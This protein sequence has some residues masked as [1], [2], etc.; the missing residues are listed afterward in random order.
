MSWPEP[1][2]TQARFELVYIHLG[3]DSSLSLARFEPSFKA[4]AQLVGKIT[5]LSSTRLGVV[6]FIM[7]A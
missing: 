6:L 5:Y 2:Y 1:E 4:R 3:S 7:Q